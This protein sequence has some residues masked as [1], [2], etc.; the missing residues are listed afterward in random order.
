[1]SL[2]ERVI[3]AYYQKYFSKNINDED[4]KNTKA[5]NM[6]YFD[7][8]LNLKKKI[9]YLYYYLSNTEI[10]T[11]WNSLGIESIYN[12]LILESLNALIAYYKNK[13]PLTCNKNK[14]IITEL[15]MNEDILRLLRKDISK[16]KKIHCICN[17]VINSYVEIKDI[18]SFLKD[19]VIVDEEEYFR[20]DQNNC[21][22]KLPFKQLFYPDSRTNFYLTFFNFFQDLPENK[23]YESFSQAV[24]TYRLKQFAKINKIKI[25]NIEKDLKLNLNK[26]Y[27]SFHDFNDKDIQMYNV[28]FEKLSSFH[29]EDLDYLFEVFNNLKIN[30]LN[31]YLKDDKVYFKTN[32]KNKFSSLKNK[33]L[34]DFKLSIAIIL[35]IMLNI[36]DDFSEAFSEN[37]KTNYIDASLQRQISIQH[38]II[39]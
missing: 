5:Y 29:Y 24:T 37:K 26:Y 28:V 15:I 18:Y 35:E 38:K 7:K 25:V 30:N 11:L 12:N 21:S 36:Q 39:K 8:N 32:I 27:E 31:Y 6:L 14:E 16:F 22:I 2:E 20:I 4:V 9:D 17:A 34:N 19:I 13:Y 10:K 33:N 23:K 3:K 1:M